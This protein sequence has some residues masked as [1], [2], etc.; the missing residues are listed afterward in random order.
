[1][2]VPKNSEVSRFKFGHET[3][4]M[5][6]FKLPPP[7][8]LSRLERVLV[9]PAVTL[10]HT[11][12]A[13]GSR[14]TADIYARRLHRFCEEFNTDPKALAAMNEKE[15]YA[16]LI[17]AVKHYR[18]RGRPGSTIVGYLKPI[19]SWLQF[20]DVKVTK[21]VRVDGANQ[22][23][24]LQDE[25]APEPHELASIWRFC[26]ERKAA[27]ISLLAFAGPRPRVLGNYG[28]TDALRLKDLPELKCDSASKTVT[29]TQLPMRVVVRAELSKMGHQYE[30]FLCEEGYKYLEAYLMKRMRS[31]EVL[32]PES[33]VIAG[34]FGATVTTKTVCLMVKKTFKHAGFKWRPY[35]LRRW[36]STRMD[37]AAAKAENGLRE[38]WI[39]FFFGHRGDIEAQYRHSK[40]LNPTQLETMREAY[41]RASYLL[42]TVETQR[43]PDMLQREFRAAALMSVG[44]T[45]GD[46]EGLDFGALTTDHF[47]ELVSRKLN[48]GV[49]TRRQLVVSPKEAERYINEG[50]WFCFQTLSSGKVVIESVGGPRV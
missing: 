11:N 20:N 29:A 12:L 8:A 4:C 6:K 5:K 25:R 2:V 7:A 17:Q 41:R 15:A 44:Y 21:K 18:A 45:N 36:F 33:P 19:I 39:K 35:I 32:G 47:Q 16:L 42:Q 9:D 1:M 50:G 23:P 48:G 10:W 40:G 38:G 22:T 37:I 43:S 49:G 46:L 24:T 31:G 34:D 3:P 30:S 14:L 13:E 26:D 28:G 27:A